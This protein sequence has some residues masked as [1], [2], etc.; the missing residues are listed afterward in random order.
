MK[1]CVRKPFLLPALVIC[2]GL[3]LAGRV[4][5]QTFQ[6]VYNFSVDFIYFNGNVSN[7]DGYGPNGSLI[8]SGNTLYGTAWQGG[9][10]GNGTVFAVSTAGTSFTNLYSFTATP[11]YPAKSTNSDGATPVAGLVLAGNTLYGT[12]SAG[13]T[14]GN[15]TVFA[16]NTDGTGFTNLHS[17]SAKATNSLGSYT[18]SD[19]Y[20]PTASLILSG[21]TLYGTAS[22]GGSSGKGTVFAVNTNGTGFTNLYSFTPTTGSL[23]TNSDGANPSAELVLSGSTLYGT[24]RNGGT[25]GYGTV[26]AIN[27]NGTGFT[28]LHT[29]MAASGLLSTNRGGAYP[30][31]GLLLAD[32]TLYG[33]TQFGGTNGNGTVFAINTNGTGFTVL[34]S[35]T[36][37]DGANP[38]A[39][40]ILASNTLYGTTFGTVFKLN[41]N[42]SS[43]TVLMTF[44][45][46]VRYD[47]ATGA[48]TNSVGYQTSGSLILS[49]NTLYGTTFLG[50]VFGSGTVFSIS[51][52]P[53]LTIMRSGTN[54]MVTWP[55]N[56]TG[57][58]LQS[59]TNLAPPVVWGTISPAPV[60]VNTN[61]IV[62]NSTSGAQ[63]FYRLSQ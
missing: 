47:P 39:S 58:T 40:L 22:A 16:I 46:G 61:N 12:A 30:S 54:V 42:G 5:A 29:F 18:N 17:F 41:T 13:G 23:S 2:L 14:N 35:L 48:E 59:T 27:T 7:S 15:G 25:N 28:V 20:S 36:N 31:A 60:A 50:A 1:T 24:A 53:Q 11:P 43:F 32:S 34:H 56:F 45:A 37:S 49:G 3:I 62:T 44:P 8:L 10:W 33:T 19:G 55:T 9:S 21:K 63:M 51:L 52:S 6:N 4:G 26:F 57:F 38:V